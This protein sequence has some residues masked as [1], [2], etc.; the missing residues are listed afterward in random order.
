VQLILFL[1]AVTSF[2]WA[3]ILVSSGGIKPANQPDTL[4]YHVSLVKAE[5]QALQEELTDN[6]YG[7]SSSPVYLYQLSD[8]C[9]D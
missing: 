3:Q 7:G 5:V 6:K 8:D 4:V 9:I 2:E 1:V